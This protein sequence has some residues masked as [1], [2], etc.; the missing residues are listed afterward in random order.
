MNGPEQQCRGRH[1]RD[2][3]EFSRQRSCGGGP[4]RC[5]ETRLSG[6][7]RTASQANAQATSQNSLLLRAGAGILAD[8]SRRDV[9]DF[10]IGVEHLSRWERV[11]VVTDIDWI[12][13]AV[14][15]VR[16]IC[17]L[18]DHPPNPRDSLAERCIR[19]MRKERLRSSCRC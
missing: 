3:C 9:E 18:R 6:H 5:D 11:A 15:C 13:H 12:K 8:G 19:R 7:P 1:A 17:G 10:K 14:I 2:S 4:R 16:E